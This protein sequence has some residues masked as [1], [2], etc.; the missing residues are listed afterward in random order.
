MQALKAEVNEDKGSGPANEQGEIQT[1]L[2]NLKDNGG[3]PDSEN[4]SDLF[5]KILDSAKDIQEALIGDMRNL[6][7]SLKPGNNIELPSTMSHI[8]GKQDKGR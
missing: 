1:I 6:G 3:I 5:R 2:K 8:M 7:I 4:I